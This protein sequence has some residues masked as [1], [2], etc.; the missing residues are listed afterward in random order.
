MKCKAA[1]LS[2]KL[3]GYLC[4]VKKLVQNNLSPSHYQKRDLTI[5]FRIITF[6]SLYNALVNKRFTR[7]AHIYQTTKRNLVADLLN[8]TVNINHH[9]LSL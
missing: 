6:L 1:I 4:E 2:I 3:A 8:Y 9:V 5:L 7:T